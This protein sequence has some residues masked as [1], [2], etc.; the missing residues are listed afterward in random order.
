MEVIA[1]PDKVEFYLPNTE[2]NAYVLSSSF[3]DLARLWTSRWNLRW[4]DERKDP[5]TWNRWKSWQIVGFNDHI[6]ITTRGPAYHVMETN[7]GLRTFSEP[8]WISAPFPT[9]LQ[10]S[11]YYPLHRHMGW[12]RL[13]D[14][15][16]TN[17]I[18]YTSSIFAI[19]RD[20]EN[21]EVEDFPRRLEI[22]LDI[23]DVDLASDIRLSLRL[24]RSNPR[25]LVHFLPGLQGYRFCGPSVDGDREYETYLGYVTD[26]VR[27]LAFYPRWKSG[28]YRCEF[29]LGPRSLRRYIRSKAFEGVRQ[30]G[31][32]ST[33]LS[34][35]ATMPTLIEKNLIRERVDL[36][37]L[38]ADY[39]DTRALGLERLSIRGQRYRLVSTGFSLDQINRYSLRIHLPSMTIL[40]PTDMADF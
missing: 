25:S 32:L 33:T 24:R 28:F 35:L 15:L 10:Q 19:L 11:K 21:I 5:D 31:I 26:G 27:Q 18:L 1:H 39:P 30:T 20:I 12:I 23:S 4:H 22:A 8:G 17:P 29:R 36:A 40:S 34:V 9:P 7:R 13:S 16:K 6:E 14:C 37:R 38:H 2:Q 3:H